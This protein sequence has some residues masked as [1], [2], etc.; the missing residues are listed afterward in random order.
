MLG[1]IS[2][3]VEIKGRNSN[4]LIKDKTKCDS[5]QQ[6]EQGLYRGELLG[7]TRIISSPRTIMAMT[8]H[9]FALKWLS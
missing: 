9:S 2:D 3:V 8:N 1:T 6:G 7:N 4:R 5:D